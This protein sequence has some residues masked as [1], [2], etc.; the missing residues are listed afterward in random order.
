LVLDIV[1]PGRLV[2]ENISI[3]ESLRE[4]SL[5]G[6]TGSSAA[7]WLTQGNSQDRQPAYSPDGEWVIFSSNRSGNLDLWEI[8]TKT[9]VLR[10]ITDDPADDWDP[11]FTPDGKQ[12]LWSSNRSGHFEIWM[13]NLDGSGPRQLTKDE[14]DNENPT[15]TRD[16]WVVYS[17]IKPGESAASV[18]KI[19][20]DGSGAS[21]LAAG[22][23]AELSPDGQY[24]AYQDQTGPSGL[25]VVRV[26]DAASVPF[27][28]SGA[29][30]QRWMPDGHAIAFT[31]QDEKGVWGVFV[32]DFTPGKDTR[33]TRRRLGV[34]DPG[35]E[36]ETFGISADGSRMTIGS[37]VRDFSLMIADHVPGVSPPKRR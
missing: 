30:A 27:E 4:V 29:G 3:R 26:A 23:N 11:G 33:N 14:G 12:I 28:I 19:R 34:F 37:P 21:R 20:Q 15:A 13:A 8:S 5:G 22:G 32:Q 1:S 7:R 6:K 17:S 31:A 24:A 10:R 35:T 36:A 18:W 2:F 16:G 25:I 9:G